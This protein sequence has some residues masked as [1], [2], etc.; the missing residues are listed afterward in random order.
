MNA[1]MHSFF[2]VSSLQWEPYQFVFLNTYLEV[3]FFPLYFIVI[4]FD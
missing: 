1:I 3:H 2:A 4:I